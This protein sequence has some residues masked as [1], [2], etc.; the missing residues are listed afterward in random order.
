MRR[1]LYALVLLPCLSACFLDQKEPLSGVEPG[2]ATYVGSFTL[3]DVSGFQ[4]QADF[5]AGVSKRKE[6]RGLTRRAAAFTEVTSSRMSAPFCDLSHSPLVSAAPSPSPTPFLQ[7]GALVIGPAL[8]GEFQSISLNDRNV[9]HL[10]LSPNLPATIYEVVSTGQGEFQKFSALIS[11]PEDIGSPTA[12][13]IRFED[14]L[15]LIQ[16]QGITLEW[17]RPAIPNDQNQLLVQFLAQTESETYLLSCLALEAA[18][19]V[20]NARLKWDLPQA[21]LAKIPNTMKAALFFTRGHVNGAKSKQLELTMQ[22][23]RTALMQAVVFTP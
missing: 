7:I 20:Q 8:Q 10:A 22:G 18:F 2:P 19:G 9:Y 12:N 16:G 13:R 14:G 5:V 1:T 3:E 4:E 11:L 15:P 21:E 23:L 17:D 6:A